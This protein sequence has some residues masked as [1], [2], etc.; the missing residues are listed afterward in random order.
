MS[1][2]V[3]LEP[4]AHRQFKD[5]VR[6]LSDRSPAGAERWLDAFN[7]ATEQLEQNADGCALAPENSLV[8]TEIR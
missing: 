7:H 6:W 8:T 3:L 4:Q 1:F 2:R 5:I